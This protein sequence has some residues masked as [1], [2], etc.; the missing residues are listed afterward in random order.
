MTKIYV[1]IGEQMLPH[2]NEIQYFAQLIYSDFTLNKNKMI[3]A[4]EEENN[5]RGKKSMFL[6]NQLQSQLL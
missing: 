4:K 1:C 3:T 2:Y 5:Q 6:K